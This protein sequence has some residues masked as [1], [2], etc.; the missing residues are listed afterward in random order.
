MRFIPARA[1]NTRPGRRSRRRCSVH[2]RA[3]GEHYQD[4]PPSDDIPGSS[5]RVRGTQVPGGAECQCQRFIPARAGNTF[6]PFSPAKYGTVHP[7]ACGEYAW[8]SF[9]YS[10][11]NGSSPRVRGTHFGRLRHSRYLRFIPAR[12]GNTPQSSLRQTLIAGS[13]PRVRGTPFIARASPVE[14]PVHPRACGEHLRPRRARKVERAV[15]P[16]ACGEH[17]RGRWTGMGPGGSSP[18]VRGTHASVKPSAVLR[19]GSSPRVRG[20][21]SR[22]NQ[23]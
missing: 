5:P 11:L 18:R 23:R 9:S 17:V 7:R 14:A 19:D 6:L 12:A 13:S 21:R 15:H 10:S 16:R 20:T 22:L 4:P 3:C 8:T 1:G 2:P